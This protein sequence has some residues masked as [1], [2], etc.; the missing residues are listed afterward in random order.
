VSTPSRARAERLLGAPYGRFVGMA[1]VDVAPGRVRLR[2]PARPDTRNRN[3]G[4]H[5]GVTAS[6]L[7]V[8]GAAAAAS[9]AP[10][11]VDAEASS[12][13]DLAVHYLAPA[14]DEG[15][16]V[17]GTVTRR[18]RELVFVEAA[19][20]TEAGVGVARSV[21]IVRFG[22]PAAVDGPPAAAPPVEASTPLE[23]WRSGSAFT[24]R[25]GVLTAR[26]EPGHAVLVLPARPMLHDPSGA[27]HEGAL[28]SLVD[29]AGGAAAWSVHGFDPQGRAAT[30]AMHLCFDRV[31]AGEDVVVEARTAWSAAGV[32]LNTVV[33]AARRSGR[34]VAA[35]SVTYRIVRPA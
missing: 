33:L 26:L 17:D 23:P 25:L 13:V 15:V 30:I 5:G 24:A 11:D 27:L 12:T 10:T 2:L 9:V 4:L 29:S 1:L 20:A 34:R 35:G 18:S 19:V 31:P 28:A 8:A 16:V 7:D 21:G 3:G 32:F 14:A 6:L 22:G